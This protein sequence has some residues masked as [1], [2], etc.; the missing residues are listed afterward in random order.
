MQSTVRL[1]RSP[2]R[3]PVQW[4]GRSFA[5]R[6]STCRMRP[7]TD[8]ARGARDTLACDPCWLVSSVEVQCNAMQGKMDSSC[9][10]R[11]AQAVDA[12]GARRLQFSDSVDTA[13][14]QR[15]PCASSTSMRGVLRVNFNSQLPRLAAVSAAI[16][17][18]S[19][20]H[21]LNSTLPVH[22][23]LLSTLCR[24]PLQR[25]SRNVC[26]TPAPPSRQ[27]MSNT[28]NPYSP[29]LY[30]LPPFLLRHRSSCWRKVHSSRAMGLAGRVEP[31][32]PPQ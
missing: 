13:F 17:L 6:G 20:P 5:S 30:C 1:A 8:Q 9:C 16:K 32:V 11:S 22:T 14:P 4:P 12:F 15:M 27:A 24:A 3:L 28:F 19:A 31:R 10:C 25:L 21:R 29:S 2:P 7:A 26:Q 18:A 23:R